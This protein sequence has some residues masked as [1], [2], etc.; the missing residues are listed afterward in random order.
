VVP[1]INAERA[2]ATSSS[3]V[4][5]GGLREMPGG[6]LPSAATSN[7]NAARPGGKWSTL[8]GG[9]RPG[10]GPFLLGLPGCGAA[11]A[12]TRLGLPGGL[13]PIPGGGGGMAMAAMG[14]LLLSMALGD[15]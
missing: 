9:T 11:G 5:F 3:S 7:A 2:A 15:H 1:L 14:G 13:R 8:G 12:P 4:G 10:G 6:G